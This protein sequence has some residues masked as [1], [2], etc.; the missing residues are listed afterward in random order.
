MS[1]D[2]YTFIKSDINN[3][4]NYEK[5]FKNYDIRAVINFAAESHV[6]RSISSPSKFMQTNIIGTFNL[7]ETSKKYWSTLSEEKKKNF[8]FVHVSTDEVYGSLSIDEQPFTENNKYKPNSPYSASKASSDHLVRAYNKTYS[9]PTLITSCS[10]NYGPFQYPEKL[11][12][13]VINNAIRE[14]PLPIYGD[15]KQIRD[16]LYVEDHCNAIIEVLNN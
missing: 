15:G 2:Q 10:N 13:L 14:K 5:E 9:L 7:L 4:N 12:P 8:R 6:D 1:N 3:L 11:I 16:W